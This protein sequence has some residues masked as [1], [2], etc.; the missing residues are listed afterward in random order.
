M[1]VPEVI[2]IITKGKKEGKIMEQKQEKII[3]ICDEIKA[4]SDDAQQFMLGFAAGRVAAA[5]KEGREP[6]Q[7]E[8]KPA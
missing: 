7:D 4:L 5:A 6:S 8:K 1:I 2:N 3:L